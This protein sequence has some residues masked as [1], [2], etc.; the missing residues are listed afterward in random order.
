MLTDY[1]YKVQSIYNNTPD[2]DNRNGDNVV[3]KSLLKFW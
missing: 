2:Y 3:Q 1:D